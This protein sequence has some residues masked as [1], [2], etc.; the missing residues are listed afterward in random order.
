MVEAKKII[1]SN[2][3]EGVIKE[4]H[5]SFKLG[6]SELLIEAESQISSRLFRT[7]LTDEHISSATLT[8]FKDIKELYQA[9]SEAI[10]NKISS[11]TLSIDENAKICYKIELMVGTLQLDRK[12]EIQLEEQKLDEKTKTAR[13]IESLARKVFEQEKIIKE[14]ANKIKSLEEKTLSNIPIEFD[15]ASPNIAHYM[16]L[17]SKRTAI[18]KNAGSWRPMLAKHPLPKS[19]ITSFSVR[20]DYST[21]GSIMV[22]ICPNSLKNNVGSLYGNNGCICYYLSGTGSIYNK[23]SCSGVSFPTGVS[24]TVIAVTTDLISNKVSFY[25]ED[26]LIR[27]VDLDVLF[28]Q[29]GDY[30]PFVEVLN[31]ND[32]VS[33][34]SYKILK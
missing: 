12:F 3:T 14:Q 17:N 16:L 23:G 28:V 4:F 7:S 33:L 18:S 1:K 10:E 25:F 24:G 31:T 34:T 22:G 2:Y 5:I 19:T 32:R 29:A 26:T 20:V 8:L 9:L 27:T 6:D 13:M 21:N 15:S 30:Y 11:I